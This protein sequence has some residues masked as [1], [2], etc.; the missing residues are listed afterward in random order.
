MASAR[1]FPPFPRRAGAHARGQS[2]KPLIATR[3]NIAAIVAALTLLFT[4][5]RAAPGSNIQPWKHQILAR[6]AARFFHR[7]PREPAAVNG[8]HRRADISETWA[9]QSQQQGRAAV[10]GPVKPCTYLVCD[11]QEVFQE[12]VI[13]TLRRQN[14]STFS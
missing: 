10:P 9:R 6:D 4:Q 14:Y 5:E 11:F 12:A 7:R 1:R 8:T 13:T 2:M 3:A